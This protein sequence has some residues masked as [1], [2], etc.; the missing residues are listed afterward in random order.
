[1][2]QVL[3]AFYHLNVNFPIAYVPAGFGN[4]FA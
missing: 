1:M 3:N 2:H 4:D